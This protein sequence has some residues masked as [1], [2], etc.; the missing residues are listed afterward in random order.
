MMIVAGVVAY[1]G[2]PS[3]PGVVITIAIITV[4]WI[5]VICFILGVVL[6]IV[7]FIRVKTG[8]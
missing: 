6:L 4:F 7:N 3:I 5:G 1:G 2:L 8:A